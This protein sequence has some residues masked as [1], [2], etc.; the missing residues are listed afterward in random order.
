MPTSVLMPSLSPTMEE[1]VLAKWLVKEGDLIKQGTLLCSVETDK[2]TVDYESMDEGYLRKIVVAGGTQAKVNQLIAILSDEKDENIDDYLK[3]ALEKSEKVAT[4]AAP[5]APAVAAPTVSA[6]APIPQPIPVAKPIPT[7]VAPS[8]SG[9]SRVKSSPLAR[10]VAAEA[11]IPLGSIQ[12]SGPSGRI[13]RRD[14]EDAKSKPAAAA[15]GT[16]ALFGSMAQVLPTQDIPLSMMRKT[17]GKR[18]L[19]SAQNTPVFFVTQ[20]IE[21][22][23]LAKLRSD[24]HRGPNLKVSVNDIV[25]KAVAFALRRHPAV[26]SAFHGDFIRQHSNIDIGIAVALEGG[27]ITPIVKDADQKSFW[28]ISQEIKALVAKAKAG[29]LAPEEYMGGTFTI[30]NLGMFGV[31][32]FTAIINPPQAAILA[33]GGIQPEVYLDA[34]GTPKQRDIMKVTI[35]ADHRVV[36]GAQA[37]QFLSTLKSALEHPVWLML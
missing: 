32:E 19:E 12:G 2:T 16:Q 8:L 9:D 18:L 37:A 3:K 35:S 1:G 31:D 7:P 21:V 20:K 6:P 23:A 10:K 15:E 27:L 5:V 29:K 17:I 33:V 13:I 25:V 11:G 4:K 36:D 22:D 24:L 34:T 30:S 14:V 26:N 28:A